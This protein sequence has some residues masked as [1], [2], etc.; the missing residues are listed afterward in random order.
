MESTVSNEL[1]IEDETEIIEVGSTSPQLK[2]EESIEVQDDVVS[3]KDKLET[4]LNDV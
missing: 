2:E 3:V 1:E 4:L